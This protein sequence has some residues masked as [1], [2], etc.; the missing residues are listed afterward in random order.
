VRVAFTDWFDGTALDTVPDE[1]AGDGSVNLE[2]FAE[3]C[4]GNAENL[5]HFLRN[6]FVALLVKEHV[7]VKLV[8]NLDLGPA[9]FLGLA[10]LLL[11]LSS[12]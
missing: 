7:V 3:G 4:T 2:L 10:A 6:L 9:L 12:L 1:G 5:C 11:C 8:L